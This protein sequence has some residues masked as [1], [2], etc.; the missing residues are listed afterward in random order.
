MAIVKRQSMLGLRHRHHQQQQQQHHPFTGSTLLCSTDV[1]SNAV[2]RWLYYLCFL[3]LILN[4]KCDFTMVHA[5]YSDAD[6]LINEL[7]RPSK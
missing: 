1:I 2:L 5:S 3:C 6:D 4:T 7:D